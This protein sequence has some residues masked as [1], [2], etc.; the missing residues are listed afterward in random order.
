MLRLMIVVGALMPMCLLT[1]CGKK[2]EPTTV[3][4]KLKIGNEELGLDQLQRNHKALPIYNDWQDKWFPGPQ[5]W[6]SRREFKGKRDDVQ[7]ALVELDSVI[8][9]WK[10][11]PAAERAGRMKE[12]ID[13][14][15]KSG[16]T[17]DAFTEKMAWLCRD[18][19]AVVIK[20]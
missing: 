18:E 11:T 6:E 7:K 8:Q 15:I 10:G 5:Y 3:E 12:L 9:E 16:V 2:S 4:I 1:G 19:I 20:K 13:S 17:G 14:V